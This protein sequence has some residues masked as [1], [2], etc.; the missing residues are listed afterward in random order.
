MTSIKSVIVEDDSNSLFVLQALLDKFCPEIE[1]IGTA[2]NVI[3]A[4][5]VIDNKEPDLVFMD[6]S[7]PDG[8][9]FDVLNAVHYRKFKTIFTTA[10]DHY[11]MKAI[12]FSAL[13]YI[14]KP[15]DVEQLKESISR[16]QKYSSEDEFDTDVRILKDVLNSKFEKVALPIQE[17]VRFVKLDQILYCEASSNYTYFHLI[18]GDKALVSRSMVNYENVFA[19]LHFCRIHNKYIINLKYVEKYEKGRRSYAI[20]EGAVALPISETRKEEFL[21]K[22]RNYVKFV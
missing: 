6:I 19:D 17:G 9:G 13:D 8:D 2:Q 21:A 15:I 16:F 5:K 7:L 4:R 11:A 3:E 18:G 20:L 10:H 12:K 1:I 14:I 22:L